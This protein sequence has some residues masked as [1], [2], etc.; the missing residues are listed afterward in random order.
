MQ[1]VTEVEAKLQ[2]QV[3]GLRMDTRKLKDRIEILE[4]QVRR[5]VDSLE[6]E[7]RENR[8]LSEVLLLNGIRED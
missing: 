2:I 4:A 1:N 5:L 8:R 3:N 6:R 7:R